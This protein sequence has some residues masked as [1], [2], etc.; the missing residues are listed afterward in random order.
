MEMEE[1]RGFY[2]P[3]E[4]NVCNDC[5]RDYAIKEFIREEPTSKFCDY[6][7]KKRRTLIAAPLENIIEFIMEGIASEWRDPNDEGVG[8]MSSEGGWI[9]A[10]V[11]DSYDLL[12]EKVDLG[13]RNDTLFS[14]ILDTIIDRQWCKKDPYAPSRHQEWLYDWESFSNQVK[15]QSR[16]MFFKIPKRKRFFKFDKKPAPYEIL[17]TLGKMVNRFGLIR[18]VNP[19]TLFIR[20][21]SHKKGDKYTTLKDL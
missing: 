6:C 12:S 19:G 2:T 1:A 14:D 21:R 11:I 8:W 5:F 17:F 16:Y 18:A 3:P 10:D 13:I 7:G 15:Y 4:K 9:G 20:A